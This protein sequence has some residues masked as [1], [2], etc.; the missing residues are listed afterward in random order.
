MED[1][2]QGD[3]PSKGRWAVA[4]P[5]RDGLVRSTYV[6]PQRK[7]AVEGVPSQRGSSA[8]A[9][10]TN[11]RLLPCPFPYQP[12]VSLQYTRE[13]HLAA[14]TIQLAWRQVGAAG[15]AMR[16]APMRRPLCTVLMSAVSPHS[17][18]TSATWHGIAKTSSGGPSCATSR[19]GALLRPPWERG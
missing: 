16:G 10:S 17:S 12:D 19:Q 2:R 1:W 4:G 18:A 7:R 8:T 9:H 11:H 13:E 14:L 5:G 6:F 3:A 15:G